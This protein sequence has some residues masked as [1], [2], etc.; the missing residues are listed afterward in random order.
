VEVSEELARPWQRIDA[1]RPFGF[2]TGE[3]LGLKLWSMPG[4]PKYSAM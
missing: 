2:D 3:Q 1:G 4:D